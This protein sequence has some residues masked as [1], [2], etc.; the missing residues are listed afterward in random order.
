MI[1]NTSLLTFLD[2]SSHLYK[3]ACTSVGWS[4]GR[5]V[6][7]QLFFTFFFFFDF[8]EIWHTCTA[9]EKKIACGDGEKSYAQI[10]SKRGLVV[11]IGYNLPLPKR[12][13][14]GERIVVCRSTDTIQ[15]K[16]SKNSTCKWKQVENSPLILIQTK[17]LIRL[18]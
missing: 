14:V 7:N 9:T 5:S 6:G 17:R 3:R 2:A 8:V 12:I 16:E 11:K 13:V 10:L 1:I 15:G 18:R 4:V